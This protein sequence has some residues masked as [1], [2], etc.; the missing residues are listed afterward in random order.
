MQRTKGNH[1]K[2]L[3]EGMMTVSYQFN[4]IN[5]RNYFENQKEILVLKRTITKIIFFLLRGLT[6]DWS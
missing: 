5:K 3:K 2:K 4:N 6:V 1:V